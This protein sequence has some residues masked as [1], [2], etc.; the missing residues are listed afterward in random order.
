MLLLQGHAEKLL[1]SKPE[2]RRKVL[3][4]IVDLERYEKLHKNADEERKSLENTLK[5]LNGQ[6]A[7]LPNVTPLALVEADRRVEDALQAHEAARADVERLLGMEARA[8]E[9]VDLQSRLA[10]ARRR[11]EQ[12]ERLLHDGASIERDV[13]RLRQLRDVLPRLQV[14]AEQRNE[15]HKAEEKS[16]EL[17]RQ[18]QKYADELTGRDHA[19]Q[20]AHD[21]RLS[22]QN[23]LDSDATRQ[24][25]TAG[26][27]RQ[28]S[29]QLEKLTECERHEND[30]Q[31]L[32]EEKKRLPDDPTGAAN[33]ARETFDNL[34]ALTQIV[35]LLTRL[36]SRRDELLQARERGQAALQARIAVEEH[37]KQIKEELE[38]TR[39]RLDAA[40][41]KLRQAA[42]QVTE[43]KTVL[44]QAPAI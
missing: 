34:T 36:A 5:G 33:L 39:P 44:Q 23:L 24:R 10:D 43:A 42:E 20:Q 19:L 21:K 6:L 31:R 38:A 3:A 37:G 14:I 28:R 4:S 8:R 30:L 16:K 9:W 40:T 13:E 29:I 35:P 32:R 11:W 26:Q 22:T 41:E 12:A 18:R 1:G 27:L 25:E 15:V 2:E 17:T 7:A